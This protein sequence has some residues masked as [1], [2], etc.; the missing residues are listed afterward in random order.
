MVEYHVSP[1]DGDWMLRN[2]NGSI[3]SKHR[4]KRPAVQNGISE[5]SE[6]DTLVIHGTDGKIQEQRNY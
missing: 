6:G 2:T 4:K 5:A 1:A 3:I